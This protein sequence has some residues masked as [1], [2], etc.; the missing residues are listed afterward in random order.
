[1]Y[2]IKIDD[3][4]DALIISIGHY[5]QYRY[6]LFLKHVTNIVIGVLIMSL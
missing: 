6:W 2:S 5:I 1:M 3:H 4:D